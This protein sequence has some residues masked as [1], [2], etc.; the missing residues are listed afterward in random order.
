EVAAEGHKS[1]QSQSARVLA[2]AD[3]GLTLREIALRAA[4]PRGNFV[5]TP[6]QIADRFE[7]WL[8]ER[9]S[10]GFNLFESLPGQ[11]EIFVD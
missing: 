4:T 2:L 10:D 3:E 11:L 6:E 8:N 9:G 5:G 7:L 1:N